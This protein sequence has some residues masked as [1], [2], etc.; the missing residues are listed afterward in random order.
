MTK[1]LKRKKL[2][3]DFKM[4]NVDDLKNYKQTFIH[5]KY[6]LSSS[7]VCDINKN[8]ETIV[9]LYNNNLCTEFKNNNVKIPRKKSKNFD[10]L[11]IE[12]LSK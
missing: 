4:K 10:H 1:N 11:L 12:K 7:T 9:L 6:N 2:S 8:K 5:D 3:L